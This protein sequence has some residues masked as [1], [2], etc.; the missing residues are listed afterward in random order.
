M[1]YYCAELPS[2]IHKNALPFDKGLGSQ[3]WYSKVG[4]IVLGRLGQLVIMFF[5][6]LPYGSSSPKCHLLKFSIIMPDYFYKYNAG[7]CLNWIV[8]LYIALP[9]QK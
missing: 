7:Y 8:C 4:G 5:L 2:Q 6:F 9:F 1:L 3:V